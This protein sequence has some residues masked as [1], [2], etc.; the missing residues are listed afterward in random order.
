MN[1]VMKIVPAIADM[2]LV[3]TWAGFRPA[4]P[5]GLPIIGED[6]DVSGLLYATGHF[7]NGILLTPV[8]AAAIAD[9]IQEATPPVDLDAFS[10]SRF[11]TA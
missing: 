7:R 3:E 11:T 8:T 1:A 2:P 5:D 10:M 9:I 6:P 4:T